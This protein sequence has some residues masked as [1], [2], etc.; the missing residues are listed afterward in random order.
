MEEIDTALCLQKLSSSESEIAFPA[1]IHPGIFTT[2][3][4]D[5]IDCLEETV[6]GKGTS[7][8]VNGIAVHVQVHCCQNKATEHQCTCTNVA[9]FNAGQ[10]VG[11]PQSKC[12]DLKIAANTQVARKKNIIWVLARL[13]KQEGQSVS[14]WT[15]FNV[16]TR[17]E[18]VV[19]PDN[20]GYLPTI[21]APATQMATVNKVLN[22]SLSIMQQLGLKK[23]VCVLIKPFMQRLLRSH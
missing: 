10:R 12:A 11:R 21:N 1:N 15:G 19:I 17:D 18:I 9:S 7:H 8:R 14:S 4:W 20:V 23:T 5:N 3:A 13:S 2:L 6:S 22:Q 16:L